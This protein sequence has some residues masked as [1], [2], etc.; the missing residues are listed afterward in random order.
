MILRPKYLT[1][2]TIVPLSRT[3]FV[4]NEVPEI[5]FDGVKEVIDEDLAAEYQR[6]ANQRRAA[7]LGVSGLVAFNQLNLA[8]GL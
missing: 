1:A 3:P 2:A 4:G 6:N 5:T 7:F 8:R